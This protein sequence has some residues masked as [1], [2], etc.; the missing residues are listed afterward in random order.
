MKP[1]F[2]LKVHFSEL[3][4]FVVVCSALFSASAGILRSHAATMPSDVRD[5]PTI[6][7]D[8]D[9]VVLPVNVTDP[10]G[11]FVSG[12]KKENFN[13]YEENRIQNLTLFQQE[14]SPVTV[15]LIVDHSGSMQPKLTNV[16]NAISA[17]AHSGNPEDEMFV[18]NFSDSVLLEPLGGKPFTSDAAE[19]GS[20]AGAASAVGR[21]ALYDAVAQG[22]VHLQLAHWQKRALIIISDGGDNASRYTYSQIL[23]LAR[24]SQVAIYA[25][26]LLDESGREENPNILKRLCQDTGGISLFPNSSQSIADFSARIAEDLREQYLLG[27]V[28]EAQTSSASFR[29]VSVNVIAPD[30]GKIRVRTRPGYSPKEGQ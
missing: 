25:I 5:Q 29:K 1:I 23:A 7:V 11:N 15:G 30:R 21:T 19:L 9:L 16:I 17:F 18:V 2:R 27:F 14:D 12:L 28:P 3:F 4:R 10:Q 6:S 22:L 26:G 8:S 24:Q 13:V 20:A